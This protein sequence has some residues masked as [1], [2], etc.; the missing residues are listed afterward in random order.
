MISLPAFSLGE[1]YFEL[2]QLCTS[3]SGIGGF[4]V[5]HIFVYTSHFD[6]ITM[7]TPFLPIVPIT[8]CFGDFSLTKD[9]LKI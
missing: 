9:F 4:L 8:A 3:I 6:F 7:L 5:K 1:M 2:G